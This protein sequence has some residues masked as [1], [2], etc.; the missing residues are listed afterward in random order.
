MKILKFV[1]GVALGYLVVKSVQG[2]IKIQQLHETDPELAMARELYKEAAENYK[3]TL[4]EKLQEEKNKK[5]QELKEKVE[6]MKEAAV[7][8]VEGGVL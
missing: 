4:A 8:A 1:G 5:K 3:E 2:I 6:K 7:E